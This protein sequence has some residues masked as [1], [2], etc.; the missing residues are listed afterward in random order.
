[1]ARTKAHDN[2]AHNDVVDDR[3]GHGVTADRGYE[4]FVDLQRDG[5]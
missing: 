1:M 5:F 4:G 2:V 3:P